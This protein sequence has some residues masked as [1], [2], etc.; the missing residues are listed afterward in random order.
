M[1]QPTVSTKSYLDYLRHRRAKIDALILA[2]E[3]FDDDGSS[4][5]TSETD[6]ATEPSSTL[7]PMTTTGGVY[8]EMTIAGAA[9]HFLRTAGKPQATTEIIRALQRGGSST[10]SK[11]MYRTVY[12]SLN[13]KLDKGLITKRK[14]KW[15][16]KE[17]QIPQENPR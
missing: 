11:N 4:R 14:G 17:W 5:D 12:N 13:T 10:K 8:S 3:E 7:V 6:V 1:H 15:G 2:I 16:L 9:I